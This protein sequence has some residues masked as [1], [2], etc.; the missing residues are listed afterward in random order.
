VAAFAAVLAWGI[1]TRD[2]TLEQIERDSDAAPAGVRAAA[3]RH[4][5][6]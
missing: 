6:V 1:E 5:Q 2:R 4:S 3:S